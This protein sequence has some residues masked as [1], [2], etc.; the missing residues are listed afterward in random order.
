MRG[1]RGIGGLDS[2]RT[3]VRSLVDNDG[4]TYVQVDRHG[5]AV[6]NGDG[7][8]APGRGTSMRCRW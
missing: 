1:Q 6:T 3:V 4:I 2:L 8:A 5:D 7:A